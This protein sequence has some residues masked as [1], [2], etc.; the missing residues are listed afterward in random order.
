[1]ILCKITLWTSLFSF[2]FPFPCHDFL[3]GQNPRSRCPNLVL[4]CFLLQ[5]TITSNNTSPYSIVIFHL[6]LMASLSFFLVHLII[7]FLLRKGLFGPVYKP[8]YVFLYSLASSTHHL[9]SNLVFPLAS[10]LDLS[11]TGFL[12]LCHSE[13]RTPLRLVA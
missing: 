11:L 6:P 10:S 13:R 5:W 2:S 9:H 1:M 8:T 3:I 12:S 4:Y 7:V